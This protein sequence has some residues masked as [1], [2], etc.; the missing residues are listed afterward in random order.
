MTSDAAA[1]RGVMNYSDHIARVHATLGIPADYARSS[2][3][4]LYPEETEMVEADLDR[5]GRTRL[6]TLAA[7]RAW[8]ELKAAAATAGYGLQL[9]S[10][11]RSVEYQRVII[12]RKRERGL[13]WEE[14]FR[15]SAAPGYSE[16][17]TGR[18]VDITTPG[19]TPLVAEFAATPAFAWLTKHAHLHGW[20]MSFPPNN[21]H[22]IAYEPW[23]WIFTGV[24]GSAPDGLLSDSLPATHPS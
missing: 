24:H 15:F 8:G 9:V 22:G 23:H 17:H 14:I 6:L 2:R 7:S 21:P 10:A 5:A 4:P 11:F 18:A 13:S 19:S 16:H 3:L 12:A 20:H 1:D